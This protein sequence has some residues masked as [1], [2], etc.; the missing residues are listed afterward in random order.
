MEYLIGSLVT[1]FVSYFV[2][3]VYSQQSNETNSNIIR[4]SQSHVY[5]LIAP[6]MPTNKEIKAAMPLRTQAKA[7]LD[8]IYVNVVVYEGKA[9]WI[10]DNEFFT[11]EADGATIL[12]ETAVKVDTMAMDKVELDKIAFIVDLLTKGERQ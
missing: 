12:K 2:Y 10:K 6:I 11:A 1:L 8:K 9:Y 5:D 3:K 4:Y 7:Y